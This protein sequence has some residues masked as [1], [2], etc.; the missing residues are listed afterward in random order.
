[1]LDRRINQKIKLY[2][3]DFALTIIAGAK[4]WSIV[5]V[6]NRNPL[7]GT[8]PALLVCCMLVCWQKY[9]SYR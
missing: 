1:M 5:S 6:A 3:N 7:K 2:N 8:I 4:F 9:I